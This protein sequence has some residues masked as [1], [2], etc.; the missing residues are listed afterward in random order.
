MSPNELSQDLKD[1]YWAL[2]SGKSMKYPDSVSL[3]EF[4]AVER[5]LDDKV[6]LLHQSSERYETNFE[7][8]VQTRYDWYSNLSADD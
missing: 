7:E 8:T 4:L 5:D 1:A 2:F 6:S 3:N